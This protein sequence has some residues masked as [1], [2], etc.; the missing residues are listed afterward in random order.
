M[1]EQKSYTTQLQELVV[2]KEEWFNSNEL[3]TLLEN[4]RLLCACVK[5]IYDLLIQKNIIQVD[6][7]RFDK[8]ISDIAVPDTSSFN[9][10]EKASIIGTRF[11][12]YYSMLDFIC[13]YIRFNTE[14]ITLPRIKKLQ[15]LNGCFNWEELSSNGA[16]PNTRNLY[17]MINDA[18]TNS[19]PMV[20]SMLT[21]HL[22]KCAQTVSEINKKLNQL[23]RF[24]REL[25]KLT[26][27]K[28]LLEHPSFN[29][30]KA[31]ESADAE[32][33]EIKKFFP[34]AMGKKPFYTE[35]VNEIV[36]EDQSPEKE[37]L[38]AEVF[39]RLEIKNTES[40]KA[41]KQKIDTKEIIMNAV[42]ILGALPP[43]Y[44][45]LLEK[46]QGNLEVLHSKKK[47]LFK[48]IIIALRTA[49]GLKEKEIEIKVSFTDPVTKQKNVRDVKIRE[50]I[51]DLTKKER[52]YTGI[53]TKGNE[54]SKIYA[55]QEDQILAF[56][57]KQISEN[58][59]MYN[60]ITA[61]DEYF[62]STASKE[63]KTK[64]KGMKLDL[65]TMRNTIINCNKKRSEYQAVIEEAAQMRKLGIEND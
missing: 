49:L 43:T 23:I 40:K 46:I 27:R 61:L 47:S 16:K 63:S 56:L 1:E 31:M 45:T 37:K 15:E 32:L 4:Y 17:N 8:K 62:K 11:S 30:E 6:P 38:R 19:P 26:I 39:A 20:Q 52:I 58:Q 2:Q 55:A 5:N 33:A 64:I 34:E 44:H 10:L 42:L 54:Y 22:T 28:D 57:G 65:E 60:T 53:S 7:Y 24:Q 29:T 13:T 41:V 9:D 12:D 25:Y 35:L 18:R 3:P 36:Q 14:T 51:D 59:N 50:L 21:D 48:K